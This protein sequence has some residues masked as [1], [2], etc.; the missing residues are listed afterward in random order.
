MT[1]TAHLLLL[2]ARLIRGIGWMVIAAFVVLVVGSL[3]A[4][5]WSM[6]SNP[7][8]HDATLA[9]LK[10]GIGTVAVIAAVAAWSWS[11]YH[12]KNHS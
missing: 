9:M 12:L 4:G 11:G 6:W 10:V 2:L 7:L 3:I 8:T 5:F 1:V